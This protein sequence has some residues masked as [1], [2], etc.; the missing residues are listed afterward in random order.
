MIDDFILNIKFVGF[1]LTM[2]AL[3]AGSII[4]G[5]TLV[6]MFGWIIVIPYV[7]GVVFILTVI[8]NLLARI[9]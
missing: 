7:I 4:G 8:D 6:E 2:F 1:F 5:L 9:I 3:V